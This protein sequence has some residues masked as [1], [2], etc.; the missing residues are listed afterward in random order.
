[1]TDTVGQTTR[2]Y[3]FTPEDARMA[4]RRRANGWWGGAIERA[5]QPPTQPKVHNSV[6]HI[7]F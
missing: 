6:S 1:M 7:L 5:P 3:R 4:P 2:L